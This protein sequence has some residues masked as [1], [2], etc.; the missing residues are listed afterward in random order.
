MVSAREAV[1]AIVLVRGEAATETSRNRQ[2]REVAG[3][4]C[5]GEGERRG[6]LR[7]A[8]QSRDLRT[9]G[10]HNRAA[11]ST[12]AASQLDCEPSGDRGPHGNNE[13]DSP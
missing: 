11:P 10:L 4:P 5:V 1:Q 7:P 8:F 3:C 13:E 6:S 9:C 2:A 12:W